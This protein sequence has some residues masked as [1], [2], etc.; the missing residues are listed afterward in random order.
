MK[1]GTAYIVEERDD[2]HNWQT[3]FFDEDEAKAFAREARQDP[4]NRKREVVLLK[5]EPTLDY[6]MSLDDDRL[7]WFCADIID[8]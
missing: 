6:H 4:N 3:L 2:F 1:H 8:Y 5:T 7:N